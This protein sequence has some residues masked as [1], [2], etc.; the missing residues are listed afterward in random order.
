MVKRVRV[1]TRLR[2]CAQ[3]SRMILSYIGKY[4]FGSNA[5]LY[6]D[7]QR[8]R[9]SG[10]SRQA[11][12]DSA[13]GCDQQKLKQLGSWCTMQQC[14]SPGLRNAPY[15]VARGSFKYVSVEY[16]AICMSLLLPKCN[17]HA[18]RLQVQSADTSQQ[19]TA[20]DAYALWLCEPLP[21]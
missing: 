14:R 11:A 13:G 16:C 6:L 21:N 5:L 12:H 10:T 15:Q 3:T 20:T 9:A 8:E 2:S 1:C 7:G 19:Q 18:T 4:F 17:S